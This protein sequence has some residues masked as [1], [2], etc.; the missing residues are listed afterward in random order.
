MTAIG[1]LR[2]QIKVYTGGLPCDQLC[3]SCEPL[4]TAIAAVEEELAEQRKDR[5]RLD[6]LAAHGH[7]IEL[8]GGMTDDTVGLHYG[9]MAAPE[10]PLREAIDT[11]R[12][13]EAERA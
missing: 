10:V 11:M 13:A 2:E 5:Q 6:W 9:L 4:A 3:P 8:R 7:P 12:A 1:R